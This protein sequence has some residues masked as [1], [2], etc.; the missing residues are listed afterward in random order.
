ML[1]VKEVINTLQ[2]NDKVRIIY[3]NDELFEG[4]VESISENHLTIHEY[5]SDSYRTLNRQQILE[6]ESI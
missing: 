5:V 1:T 6:I 3:V 2:K 4:Y